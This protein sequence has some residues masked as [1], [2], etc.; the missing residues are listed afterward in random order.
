MDFQKYKSLVASLEFG[1]NL[2]NAVYIHQSVLGEINELLASISF[3]IAAAVKL[4]NDDWNVI[5][6][7]KRD[8]KLTL[9]NYPDFFD[10]PYPALHQ[11]YTIDLSKLAV[12]K[13][14]YTDSEN[15][16]IL[17]R[18]ETLLPAGHKLIPA[19]NKF[20]I[21][22]ENI[23]LYDNAKI[24]GF[25]QNWERL[26]KRKGYYLDRRG[27]IQPL[28]TNQY[29][30]P[31][32]A[33]NGQI[34]RHKTALSRDKLSLPLFLLGQR[35]YLNGDY[36]IL[37]YGCGKGDDLRELQAHEIDCMGWDPVYMPETDIEPCDIVNLGYVINV[38]EDKQ[39]RSETLTRA[40]Q[41]ADKMLLVSAMLGNE[42][43][44][45]RFKPYKD[46]VRTARNTFQKYYTQG[47]L[48]TYIESVLQENAIALSPGIFLVFKN[49]IEE[50]KYLLERQRTRYQWRQL[51][52]RPSQVSE[53]IAKTLFEKHQELF[54]HFWATCM[55]A[56]RLPAN[57]EFEYSSQIRK[58]AGSHD[59]ALSI[60]KINFENKDFEK[61]QQRRVDDLLTYFALEFFGKRNAYSR[62]PQSFQ[63]DIKSFFGKYSDA[64][65]QGKDLLYSIAKPEIIYKAC[66]DANKTLPASVLNEDHD[67]I[68]HKKYL[69]ECPKELRIFIGCAIQ[70]YGELE[71]VDL[72][73]AHIR[74]GKVTF[75]VHE[76]FYDSPIPL[77]KERIKIKLAEQDI[78]FFDYVDEFK[79]QPL[80]W[81]SSYIDDSFA[82]HRKQTLFDNKLRKL[83]IIKND[84]I[85]LI[86]L[87]KMLT[88][89][90][91]KISGYQL[92]DIK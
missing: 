82:D 30:I 25:K 68:F 40:F 36:S 18:R 31:T 56:G 34:D 16:P 63:R 89:K 55:D 65:N 84:R 61:A 7:Y 4:K 6:F 83:A 26:I 35:E 1:K 8:F 17:H 19:L 90:G 81:K 11:S 2:P 78:D 43:I 53:S 54:E 49:K 39:E 27:Y 58:I 85:G 47:E 21:E 69:N 52:Q 3:K 51:S 70:L 74:S 80:L 5:K 41:F 66:I 32:L 73:K 60:C 62:M 77:L 42:K 79:P 71:E 59:K 9:L 22:G 91:K 88:S 14:N 38:I 64:R 48:K 28:N 86:E 44:F 67:L 87:N 10:Y 76:G 29:P 50:Q 92:R 46:G 13:A 20:T 37:D 72:I 12:R 45:E 23:G 24:I 15:P 57:E 33:F 75:M